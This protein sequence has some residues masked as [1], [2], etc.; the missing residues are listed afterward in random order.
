MDTVGAGAI[1]DF[2]R[3]H[4]PT[5]ARFNAYPRQ[6]EI[7]SESLGQAGY[8]LENGDDYRIANIRTVAAQLL[9]ERLTS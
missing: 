1:P 3:P 9:R 5:G 7:A 6:P 4:S 2:R 8:R